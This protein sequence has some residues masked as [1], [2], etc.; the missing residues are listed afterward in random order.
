MGKVNATETQEQA[1]R[2]ADKL[3]QVF[4]VYEKSLDLDVALTLVPL[5]E[6]EK[7][8]LLNDN[9]LLAR[10]ALCDAMVRDQLMSDFRALARDSDSDGVKLTALKELGRTLYPRR[11]KDVDQGG[12]QGPRTIKYE[13]V[14]PIE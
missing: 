7:N 1:S 5:S 8:R 14:E 10:V 13:L 2:Y 3:E 9:D 11:F 6:A 4:R 12:G